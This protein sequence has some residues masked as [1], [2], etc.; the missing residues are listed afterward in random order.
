MTI[1]NRAVRPELPTGTVTF[2]FTDIEGS[3]RLLRERGG[4]LLRYRSRT[5]S[6]PSA[7]AVYRDAAT[8][9]TALT[10]PS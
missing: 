10:M 8:L 9:S 1:E 4:R 2:L 5:R 6:G 3:T 7:R